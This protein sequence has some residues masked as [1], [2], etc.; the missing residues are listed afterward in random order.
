[1]I[2]F[3]IL[4]TLNC[5]AHAIFFVIQQKNEYPGKRTT[6]EP[7]PPAKES[8]KP[9]RSSRVGQQKYGPFWNGTTSNAETITVLVNRRN[10][11]CFIM[12]RRHPD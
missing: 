2:S 1:M 9:R 7:M 6:T 5:C 8:K 11:A 4:L 3:L 12:M 10:D